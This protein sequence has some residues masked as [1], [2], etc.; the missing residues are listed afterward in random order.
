MKKVI[1]ALLL[2]LLSA[3]RV[4]ATAGNDLSMKDVPAHV[5][6]FATDSPGNGIVQ[7]DPVNMDLPFD[8]DEAVLRLA[9]AVAVHQVINATNAAALANAITDTGAAQKKIAETNAKLN[10]ALAELTRLKDICK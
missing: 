1:L 5:P 4:T 3:W 6:D 2:A 8:E 9:K 7:I 10:D